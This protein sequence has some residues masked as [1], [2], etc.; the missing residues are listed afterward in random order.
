MKSQYIAGQFYA[1]QTHRD[2]EHFLDGNI[3]E[4][5]GRVDI[6]RRR[7]EAITDFSPPER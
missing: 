3:N 5:R 4:G 7:I 2:F 6:V 1:L